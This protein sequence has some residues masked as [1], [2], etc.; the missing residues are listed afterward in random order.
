M[1]G[2]TVGESQQRLRERFSQFIKNPQVSAGLLVQRPVVVTVTGE[3]AR[4]GFYPLQTP[5][6]PAAL[7]AAAGTTRIGRTAGGAGA[8][9]SA[10]GCCRGA[11]C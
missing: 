6:L 8:A 1:R 9:D 11:N 10:V 7:A 5:Q 4:P 3:V 2:L